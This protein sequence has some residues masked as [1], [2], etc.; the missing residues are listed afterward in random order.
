MTRG[1][2]DPLFLGMILV[3]SLWFVLGAVIGISTVWL[4]YRRRFTAG[5]ALRAAIFGGIGLIASIFVRAWADNYPDRW[6]SMLIVRHGFAVPILIC[7]AVAL[8]A[9]AVG[10]S[11]KEFNQPT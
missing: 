2:L 9:G 7:C 5:L 1:S 3:A 11:A 4:V 10:R 6:F 8:L